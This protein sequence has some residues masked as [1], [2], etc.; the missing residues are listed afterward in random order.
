VPTP[1]CRSCPYYNKPTQEGL[2][3][4]FRKVAE[5]VDCRSSCTNVAGPHVA[6]LS[7]ETTLRLTQVPVSSA[8]RTHRRPGRG[9]DLLSARQAFR[10]LQR[11]RRHALAL[12]L[13]GATRHLGDRNIAP[14]LMASCAGGAAATCRA[15]R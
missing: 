2:Y 1:R 10:R 15:R 12:M 3:Q 11:Q 9:S 4:H 13:L 8:S 5:S 7:T 14:R 6:D